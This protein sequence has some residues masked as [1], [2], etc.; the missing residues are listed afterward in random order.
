MGFYS[1]F[2]HPCKL[3]FRFGGPGSETWCV[4]MVAKNPRGSQS[5]FKGSQLLPHKI[6]LESNSGL[7]C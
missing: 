4:S 5:N 6:S 7:D 3:R 2:V 1:W